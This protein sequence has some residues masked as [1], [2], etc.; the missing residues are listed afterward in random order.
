VIVPRTTTATDQPPT[1]IVRKREM[2]DQTRLR[3]SGLL[4]DLAAELG[5]SR[6]SLRE[7][8]KALSLINILDV[9]QGDGTYVTSLEPPL[10]LEA[11]SFV[12]DFHRDDEVLE[13]LAVR[14]IL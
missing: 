14:R 6:N 1:A 5:L 8:V 13:Y 7:A 3:P 9:R 10:L 4:R 12:I 11:L 2:A